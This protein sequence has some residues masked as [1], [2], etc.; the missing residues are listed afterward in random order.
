MVYNTSP[1]CSYRVGHLG[2]QRASRAPLPHN[3]APFATRSTSAAESQSTLGSLGPQTTQRD[4][5]SLIKPHPAAGI[6]IQQ[7]VEGSGWARPLSEH[8]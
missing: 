4:F 2:V 5:S 1:H 8:S 7:A 3:Q 6:L